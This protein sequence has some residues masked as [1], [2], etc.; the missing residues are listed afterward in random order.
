MVQSTAE[1]GAVLPLY[2]VVAAKLIAVVNVQPPGMARLP[3]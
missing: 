1:D 2:V 3:A